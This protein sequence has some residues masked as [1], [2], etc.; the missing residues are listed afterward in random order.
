MSVQMKTAIDAD[1]FRNITTYEHGINLFLRV[2]EGLNMKTVMHEFV[3]ETEL[4]GNEYLRQ[5][6]DTKKIEVI[7]YKDYIE[8]TDQNNYAK[9]F[10][11]AFERINKYDFPNNQDIYKYAEPDESLGE[12]RSLYM[13]RKWVSNILCQMMQV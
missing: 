9:Y 5:L 8:D 11:T 10:I 6:S 7:H 1:F 4:K 13:A 3:A 2:M 12:I